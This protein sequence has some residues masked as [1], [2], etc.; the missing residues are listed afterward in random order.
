MNKR[1]FNCAVLRA[2]S[3]LIL[4]YSYLPF[5]VFFSSI[6]FSSLEPLTF[7]IPLPYQSLFYTTTLRS[8]VDNSSPKIIFILLHLCTSPKIYMTIELFICL[9]RVPATIHAARKHTLHAFIT[10]SLVNIKRDALFFVPV[11]SSSRECHRESVFV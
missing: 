11:T 10:S 4:F 9:N 7:C 5:S 3:S 1:G 6:F 2:I 8:S